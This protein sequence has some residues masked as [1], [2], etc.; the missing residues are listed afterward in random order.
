[1]E[2][3]INT[4]ESNLILNNYY[5]ESLNIN[6]NIDTTISEELLEIIE[7]PEKVVRESFEAFLKDKEVKYFINIRSLKI[8][9]M[10][11]IS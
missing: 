3:N 4:E 8:I 9:L 7:N 10:N 5:I 11:G 1:M 6:N 2:T